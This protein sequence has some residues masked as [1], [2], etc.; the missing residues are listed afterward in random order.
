MNRETRRQR[1]SAWRYGAGKG[2]PV[3][4]PILKGGMMHAK[5]GVFIIFCSAVILLSSIPAKGE[6]YKYIDKDGVVHYTDNLATIPPEYRKEL[7]RY[8][9][10]NA[11]PP[12][13]KPAAESV[14]PSTQ[15]P[16]PVAPKPSASDQTSVQPKVVPA[17]PPAKNLKT[18]PATT[19]NEARIKAYEMKRKSLLD[20]SQRLDR[21]YQ[22]LLKQRRQLEESRDGLTTP[23]E[24]QGYND[25]VRQLNESINTYR[26]KRKTLE[27]EVK[28]FNDS[29]PR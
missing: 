6:I 12:P 1:P 24:I 3:I 23:A 17:K 29:L 10:K 22:S 14:P 28:N 20:K 21:E 27:N 8:L 15:N 9:N 2:G 13:V 7:D 11:S 5:Y 18:I 4:Q 26:E 16:S 25:S 19:E